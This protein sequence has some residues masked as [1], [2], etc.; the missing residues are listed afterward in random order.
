MGT[1][2]DRYK[3][4]LATLIKRGCQLLDAMYAEH[5]PGAFDEA[6][7][8]EG[9]EP[10]D[11]R[12]KLPD[13]STDYQAWYS[14]AKA[15]LKQLLPDRLDDF[16]RHYEKPKSRKEVGFENYT[17]ADAL[18][19]LIIT[20]YA[21]KDP[22]VS[23]KSAIPHFQQQLYMVKAMA[24]RFESSLFDIRQIVQADLFDSELDAARELLKRGFVR[25]AGAVAGVVLERHLK[26][27]V[28]NHNIVTR[29]ATPTIGDL[30]DLLKRSDVIDVPEWR[31]IQRLADLRNLCDH[32]KHREP[33]KEE[34]GDLIDGTDKV[35]KTL[36]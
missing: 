33:T 8:A 25:A 24:A 22:I 26:Q 28:S 2:L 9:S 4:D 14:E 29:K 31:R 3:K 19:G 18:Q 12:E 23:P 30:N 1:N 15:L 5:L 10:E 11:V 6:V 34:A 20:H 16:V 32:E 17:I 7:K 13:F 21:R 27:V 35:L 36:F